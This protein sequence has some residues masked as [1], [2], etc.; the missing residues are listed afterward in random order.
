MRV[1]KTP[2]DGFREASR[3]LLEAVGSPLGEPEYHI[4]PVARTAIADLLAHPQKQRIHADDTIPEIVGR[5]DE[6]LYVA[7][8]NGRDQIAG[9]ETLRAAGKIAT[10]ETPANDIE[11][12]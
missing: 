5:A 3:R 11:L 9:Y 4:D 12:F 10:R 8:D 7:K 6:A 1:A 2:P